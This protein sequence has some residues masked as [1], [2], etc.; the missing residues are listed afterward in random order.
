MALCILGK[1][2]GYKTGWLGIIAFKDD[3]PNNIIAAGYPTFNNGYLSTSTM[4]NMKNV[5]VL[6]GKNKVI[7]RRPGNSGFNGAPCFVKT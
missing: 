1:P 6:A 3:I 7:T 2:L 4:I 5:K